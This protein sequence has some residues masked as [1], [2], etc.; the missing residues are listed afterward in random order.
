MIIVIIVLI[1]NLDYCKKNFLTTIEFRVAFFWFSMDQTNK[2]IM[3]G[4]DKYYSIKH[5]IGVS[6]VCIKTS[7]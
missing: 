5:T 4:N 2:I 3:N 7:S 6:T 1:I